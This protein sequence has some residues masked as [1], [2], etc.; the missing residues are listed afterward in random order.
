MVIRRKDEDGT[1]TKALITETPQRFEMPQMPSRK[2]R[3]R[4]PIDKR[5]EREHL[6]E[7]IKSTHYGRAYRSKGIVS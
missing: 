7:G 5:V 2:K 3:G 6:Q 1:G 4:I